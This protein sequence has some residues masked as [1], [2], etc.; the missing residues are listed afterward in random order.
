MPYAH[1]SISTVCS[2]HL[3][4]HLMAKILQPIPPLSTPGV[5][6]SEPNLGSDVGHPHTNLDDQDTA[7]NIRQRDKM[8]RV[9]ECIRYQQK[10]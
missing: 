2:S 9:K 10:G 5:S 8:G 4:H 6:V 3:V 7:G 1:L